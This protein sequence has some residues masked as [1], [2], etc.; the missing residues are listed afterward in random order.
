MTRPDKTRQCELKSPDVEHPRLQ[1]T[2]E[3][4]QLLLHSTYS[5]DQRQLLAVLL[6]SFHQL[7]GGAA[8]FSLP[9]VSLLLDGVE[10]TSE[11]THGRSEDENY[12]MR[13]KLWR[14]K[15]VKS[16]KCPHSKITMI[17]I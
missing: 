17:R 2:G 15:S 4:D 9:P 14:N 11:E 5:C 6:F 13:R 8:A 16:W 7:F 3:P 12:R 10:L 1:T